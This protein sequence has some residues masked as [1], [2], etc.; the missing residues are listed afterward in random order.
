MLVSLYTTSVYATFVAARVSLSELLQAHNVS[1]RLGADPQ[2]RDGH[3]QA[4]RLVRLSLSADLRVLSVLMET[5]DAG[6]AALL[7]L[8]TSL[9]QARRQEINQLAGQSANVSLL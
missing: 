9:L 2:P 7:L 6:A 4:A 8:D 1:V 3:P 5:T